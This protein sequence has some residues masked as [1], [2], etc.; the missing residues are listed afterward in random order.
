[1]AQRAASATVA[2]AGAQPPTWSEIDDDEATGRGAVISNATMRD[3]AALAGVGV[4][5]VSRVLN[6]EP[7]VSAET[8]ERVT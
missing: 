2:R 6:G 4:K 7:N 5:T 1:L 3:V 8:S